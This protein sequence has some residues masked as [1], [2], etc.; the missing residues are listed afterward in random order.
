MCNV[1]CRADG[2]LCARFV[3]GAGGT[4]VSVSDSNA[5]LEL[6]GPFDGDGYAR[7]YLRNVSCGVFAGDTYEV[8]LQAASGARALVSASSATSV[9]AMPGGSASSVVHLRSSPD[10]VLAYFEG[11]TILQRDSSLTHRVELAAGGGLAVYAEVVVFGRM[12]F[13][14]TLAFREYATEIIVLGD[15][16][17]ALYV[18]RYTLRPEDDR[19]SLEHAAAPV[20][21]TIILAGAT[22][23]IEPVVQ[24]AFE[25]PDANVYTGCDWLPSDAAI[26]VRAAGATLEPITRIIE[27]ALTAVGSRAWHS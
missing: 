18:E 21:G 1:A 11:P 26:V 10:A 19:A 27:A 15:S 20:M 25:Q 14:E 24:T 3:G 22:D 4:R 12:A 17:E 5:P 9:H 16:G 23:D 8:H 7:F 13:G 2:R 6:R